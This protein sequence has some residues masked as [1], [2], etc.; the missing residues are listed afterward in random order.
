MQASSAGASLP[1]EL[2][3][4][5]GSQKQMKSHPVCEEQIQTSAP[6]ALFLSPLGKLREPLP[7]QKAF[8]QS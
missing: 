2:G 3:E 1:W 4:G 8:N 7:Q 6:S 5:R